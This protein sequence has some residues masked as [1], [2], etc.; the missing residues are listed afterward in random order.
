MTKTVTDT[1]VLKKSKSNLVQVRLDDDTKSKLELVLDQLG[2]T[3]SQA[4]LMYIK[5][6]VLKKRIP[7]ELTTTTIFDDTELTSEEFQR[8]QGYLISKLDQGE[9]MPDFHEKNARAFVF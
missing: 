9:I 4:I 6:I 1:R 3:T 8:Q 7:L 5:Q 2:L